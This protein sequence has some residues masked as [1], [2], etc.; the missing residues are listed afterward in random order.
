MSLD[1]LSKMYADAVI[2]GKRTIESVPVVIREQVTQL[3]A[4]RRDLK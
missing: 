1:Y 3:I 2:T 4:E